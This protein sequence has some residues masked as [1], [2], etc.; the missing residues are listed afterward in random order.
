MV[1]GSK[2]KSAPSPRII[3]ASLAEMIQLRRR[4]LAYKGPFFLNPNSSQIL[5]IDNSLSIV[6]RSSIFLLTVRS[7]GLVVIVKREKSNNCA[8]RT[9]DV[10]ALLEQIASNAEVVPVVQL[11]PE[12][13]AIAFGIDGEVATPLGIVKMGNNQFF[14]SSQKGRVSKSGMIKPTLTNPDIIIEDTS[15]A[16]DGQVTERNSSYIFVKV[17]VKEGSKRKYFF[18]SVS[19]QR[20]G[21]EVVKSNQEK[22]RNRLSK[23]LQNGKVAWINNKFSLHPTAQIQE[24]VPV[25]DSNRPTQ[26]D[27]QSALLGINSSELPIDKDTQ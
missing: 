9:L 26:S 16:K 21:N 18:T 1:Y 6:D 10:E 17:F 3:P 25:N 20:G 19:V 13:W 8:H 23:L 12:N 11:T 27:N 15:E 4:S 22:S 2:I 14:K 24:P 7:F 5:R